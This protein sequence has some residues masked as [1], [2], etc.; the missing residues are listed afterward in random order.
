MRMHEEEGALPLHR[1]EG[2]YKGL[3]IR[4]ADRRNYQNLRGGQRMLEEVFR[5]LQ[6]IIDA[7]E[8]HTKEANTIEGMIASEAAAYEM[9]RDLI[10]EE[11]TKKEEQ[12]HE[13]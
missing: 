4:N 1:P 3:Q 10:N 6:Y 7:A 11:S 13:K 2:H 12:N 9:M 8:K 5:K